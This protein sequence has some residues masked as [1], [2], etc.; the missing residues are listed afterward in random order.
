MKEIKMEKGLSRTEN[1]YE[2]LAEAGEAE[3]EKELAMAEL[4]EYAEELGGSDLRGIVETVGGKA[5]LRDVA[6]EFKTYPPS[7][8]KHTQIEDEVAPEDIEMV[9]RDRI[10]VYSYEIATDEGDEEGG[11][12][13]N[14]GNPHQGSLSSVYT[15]YVKN[16]TGVPVC[17]CPEMARGGPICHH[18]MLHA[19][20]QGPGGGTDED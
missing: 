14:D 4:F 11:T 12:T 18:M 9:P 5:L 19:V 7:E 6:T 15:M 20:R 8:R 16:E 13:Q 1:L 3:P 17:A 10:Y 2:V